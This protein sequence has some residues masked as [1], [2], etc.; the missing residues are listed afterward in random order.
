MI[1]NLS[2]KKKESSKSDKNCDLY[3]I[4][5]YAMYTL[6]KHICTDQLTVMRVN[7]QRH[8]IVIIILN[9]KQKKI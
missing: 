2:I 5:C 6:H 4:F 7:F 8:I 9:K 1:V 3:R